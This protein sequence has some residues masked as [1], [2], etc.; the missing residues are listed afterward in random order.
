MTER[1]KKTGGIVLII[2]VLLFAVGFISCTVSNKKWQNT[3]AA[4][5][6][7]VPDT[8]SIY[9]NSIRRWSIEKQN[10]SIYVDSERWHNSTEANQKA[11]MDEVVA[12]I[13]ADA[14][15]TGITEYTTVWISFHE[16]NDGLVGQYTLKKE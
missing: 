9:G 6:Q 5:E 4:F 1:N 15:S 10:I 11:F 8:L 7:K 12:L 16:T 2:I 13:Q 3:A 14:A